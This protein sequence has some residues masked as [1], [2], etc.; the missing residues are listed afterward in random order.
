MS[1]DNYPEQRLKLTLFLVCVNVYMYASNL[2]T[3][4]N[5]RFILIHELA[6]LILKRMT[7][8][9]TPDSTVGG[10]MASEE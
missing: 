1:Q 6:P 5:T 8:R 10:C 3:L 2:A 9:Y 7:G 4:H